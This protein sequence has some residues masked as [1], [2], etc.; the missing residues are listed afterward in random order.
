MSRLSKK[1]C[2][3][4]CDNVK[5]VVINKLVQTHIAKGSE[6]HTDGYDIYNDLSELGYIHKSVLHSHGL[7]AE[8]QDGDGICEV[9]CNSAEGLWSLLRPFLRGFRGLNK[10]N[11]KYYIKLFE[12]LYNCRVENRNPQQMFREMVV[13]K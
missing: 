1:N 8:D 4:V 6:I 11:L 3:T 12:Y 10:R 9:H 2:L 5:K 7:Y 13:I